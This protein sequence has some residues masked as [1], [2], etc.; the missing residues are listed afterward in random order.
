MI[1]LIIDIFQKM[2]HMEMVIQLFQQKTDD[3][4]EADLD[5]D[6]SDSTSIKT[7]ATYKISN[8]RASDLCIWWIPGECESNECD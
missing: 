1:A 4:M 2:I 5:L 7:R 6:E 8:E 3:H